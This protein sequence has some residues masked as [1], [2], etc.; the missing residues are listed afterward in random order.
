MQDLPPNRQA[1][2]AHW[3]ALAGLLAARL[4]R[5][6]IEKSPGGAYAT[7]VIEQYVE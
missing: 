1:Y 5:G 2:T 3:A 6:S 7:A 4:Q